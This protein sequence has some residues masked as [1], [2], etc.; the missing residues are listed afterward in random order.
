VITVIPSTFDIPPEIARLTAIVI[1][2]QIIIA[3]YYE[4][5]YFILFACK[6]GVVDVQICEFVRA[7]HEILQTLAFGS[8]SREILDDPTW[9][10]YMTI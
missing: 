2:Y 8:T 4:F 6:S 10:F 1:Q 7:I 5:I 9:L 3:K